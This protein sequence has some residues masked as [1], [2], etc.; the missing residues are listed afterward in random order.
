MLWTVEASLSITPHS[1]FGLIKM[2]FTRS[3]KPF[4][5]VDPTG[6]AGGGVAS[7]GLSSLMRC[8]L[9]KRGE[10]KHFRAQITSDPK[11]KKNPRRSGGLVSLRSRPRRNLRLFF[12]RIG[13]CEAAVEHVRARDSAMLALEQGAAAMFL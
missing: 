4:C 3:T 12:V 2:S 5:G 6:A 13:A 11:N 9:Q 7:V 1:V 8:P 10:M